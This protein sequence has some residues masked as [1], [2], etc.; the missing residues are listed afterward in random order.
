MILNCLVITRRQKHFYL[1]F[2]ERGYSLPNE[3]FDSIKLLFLQRSGIKII[4]YQTLLEMDLKPSR[5][6][7]TQIWLFTTPYQM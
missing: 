7:T 3:Y 6:K 2:A 1:F 5:Q 4:P